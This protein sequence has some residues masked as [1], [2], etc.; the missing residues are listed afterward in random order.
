MNV[1]SMTETEIEWSRWARERRIV[2][3]TYLTLT[4]AALAVAVLILT[5]GLPVMAGLMGV[6][7]VALLILAIHEFL[8]A[9][10][11]AREGK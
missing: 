6:G 11:Y 2:G 8:W 5:I 7:G 3:L 1:R 4:A 9:R 10:K